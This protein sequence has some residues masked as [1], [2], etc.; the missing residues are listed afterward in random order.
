MNISQTISPV[1]YGPLITLSHD[2]I[3]N[4]YL[5]WEQT[6]KFDVALDLGFINDRILFTAGYYRNRTTDVL[7]E[8]PLPAQAGKNSYTANFDAVVQNQGVE[9]ELNTVNIGNRQF[10]WTSSFNITIP[11]NKLVS[12]PGL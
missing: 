7:G 8:V 6:K 2:R 11:E 5:K 3:A 10:K 4:P 1:L 12:F 9:L